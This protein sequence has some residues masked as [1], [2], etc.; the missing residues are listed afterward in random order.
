MADTNATTAQTL[1][2]EELPKAQNPTVQF[3]KKFLRRKT[4]VLGF[5][6][7]VFILI[8]AV[9]GPSIVPYDPNAYDYGAIL[10]GPSATHIWGTD[11]FGR[12]VFSRILAGTQLSLGTALTASI[13]GTAGGVV[14]GLIA[15]FFGGIV[16]SIIMRICDVMFAFPSILLAIAIVAII[17]PGITNIMIGLAVFTVPSFARIIRG[18]V[19][20]VRGELY[21]EV[22]QS[23]GCSPAR[24]MFVHI[25]PG[26]MQALIVNFTMNVGGAILSASSLSFLGFGANVTQAEWGA[27]LSQGRNYLAIAPHLV[28]FPGLVIFL[29][30]LAFNLFGDG[31]RDTLDPKLN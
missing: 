23:I 21:V 20:E 8:M 14:L 6:F 15:G 12:D 24:T 26:T 11:E 17:G 31:L 13:L 7:I 18:A 1:S 3:I 28:L 9:I 16:D 5:L 2:A 27:I 29:T 10:A 19:L 4:A 22:A 25:F 30:V